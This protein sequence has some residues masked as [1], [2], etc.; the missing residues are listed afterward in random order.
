MT[1][2]VYTTGFIRIHGEQLRVGAATT[3]YTL[4]LEPV[5]DDLVNLWLRD[6][7]L[8]ELRIPPQ[9]DG[10]DVACN[11]YLVDRKKRKTA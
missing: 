7:P 4:G 10:I 11:E 8:G 6:V 5:G 3:G 9:T 1:R 2:Q